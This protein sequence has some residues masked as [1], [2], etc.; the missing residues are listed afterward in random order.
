M[1]RVVYVSGTRADYGLIAD[2][3]AF[4]KASGHLDVS[5][6]V[7]GMHLL[8]EYGYTVTEIERHGLPVHSRIPVHLNG[9]TGTVMAKAIGTEILGMA[10]AF[11]R[12]R[13]D[14]VM[15]LGDRGEM[16]AAAIAAINL[17][18]PVV[19]IHGGERSGTVD[20]PVRHAISKL[21]HYHFVATAAAKERL[22]RMGERTDRVFVTGAPGLDGLCELPARTR[23]ELCDEAEFD[24]T[25]QVALVVFH[26]VLQEAREAGRQMEEIL[27]A[28]LHV[29]MQAIC[30][31]PNADAGGLA[32][33]ET[34][35]RFRDRRDIRVRVHLPRAD[36]VSWMAGVD[37]MI[38]NS[39]SGI[40]E[41]ATFGLPV[42][43]VGSRQ[44]LRERAEGV[45]DVPAEC[46]AIAAAIR[47]ALLPDFVRAKRNIYGDGS[48]GKRIVA[49]LHSLPLDAE[50][51]QKVNEY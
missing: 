4:A 37:V 31:E 9:S 8:P 32:I 22:I 38:G 45:L 25:R 18:I 13:P 17:N 39:S 28:V 12:N 23:K 29:G 11:T 2:T 34:L 46:N 7:T 5:V 44:R 41:A 40:I 26:P 36:Y 51:L 14:V 24:A 1:R 19:H 30:L 42:V 43:N 3:L 49:L 33:R 15:V 50:I 35:D 20:E 10:D 47:Q 6:C 27:C 16:L 48:A 21:S